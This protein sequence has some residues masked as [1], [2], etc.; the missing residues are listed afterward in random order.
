MQAGR[1][2]GVW[3]LER[4]ARVVDEGV[5]FSV[6]A[7]RA[8]AVAVRVAGRGRLPLE[9]RGDGVWAGCFLGAAAGD[10]YRFELTGPEGTA[11]LPDPVSRHQPAGV[12]GPSRV[13]DPARHAWSDA[14]WAGRPLAAQVLYELHV[15]TFTDAGT[16]DGA[17][18][19]LA[20]LAALGVTTV[21]LMPV[22][23]FPGARNW[24]YDGVHLYAPQSTYGGPDGL[25]RLVDAAHAARLGVVLDVVYNHLGPE[26]NVLSRYGPY[27]TDRYRTPWGNAVNYDDAGCDE[28]RRFV[29]DNARYWVTEFHVDGL[30]LDAV[31]AIFDAG[32]RPLLAELAAAVH[33]T[34]AALG[35]RVDVIAESD[36]NDARLVRDPGRGGYGLDAQWSDDFH[37]AVHAALTG[38]RDGYYG[39]FGGVAPVAKSLRDR[40]VY[41]GARSAFRG[42]RHGGPAG[43]VPGDRFVVFTQNHDQVGNRARGERLA[44]L[45]DAPRDRLGAA[46]LLLAPYVPL[47]FMGQ[48]YGETN[49]FLYF[50]DHQDP[51][52]V[53]AVRAGRRAE[54]AAFAWQGDVPDPQAPETF[55]RSRLD[56]TRVGTP[57]HG[58]LFALYHDLLALRRVEPALRPGAGQ[59]TVAVDPDAGWITMAYAARGLPGLAAAFNLTDGARDVPLPGAVAPGWYVRLATDDPRYGGAGATAVL[60]GG[61]VALPPWTACVLGPP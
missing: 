10:D 7:P 29:L 27:F 55:A 57:G 25:R 40:F 16:F 3:H 37:H 22:A 35:R 51:A 38:E 52:L 30:R 53:A 39:D 54:F 42:R 9:A 36:L 8:D 2:D 43:D 44:A 46:L 1:P 15:G 45:T 19:D 18:A 60:A 17:I 50:T 41:D 26:G 21:E 23:E 33:E 59:V 20:R 61:R 24:G 13:V 32:A 49:P 34:A 14:G 56:R 48:E 11:T 28:V 47:L 58:E 4:G 5:A 31:H 12:H 6:W